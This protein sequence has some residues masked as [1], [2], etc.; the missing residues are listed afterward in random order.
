VFGIQA[1]RYA[2]AQAEVV[3]ILKLDQRNP[4]ARKWRIDL[5]DLSRRQSQ[6]S[7]LK[8]LLQQAEARVAARDYAGAEDFFQDALELVPGNTGLLERI[9]QVRVERENKARAEEMLAEA[10]VE[11]E[12]QAFTSAFEHASE[13]ART[14]PLSQEAAELVEQVA[15]SQAFGKAEFG[16]FFQLR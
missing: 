8:V 15:F 14:D 12:R 5:K 2:E 16:F 4:K 10:R 6:G 11:F 7:R 9:R 1:E 3:R 13:A